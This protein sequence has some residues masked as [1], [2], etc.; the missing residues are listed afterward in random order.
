MKILIIEDEIKTAK[1]LQRIL[2]CFKGFD[3]E[4]LA[5][6]DSVEES[7]LYLNN[8]PHPDL[9]FSDI[10]LADGLCFEIFNKISVKSPVI[11]C[12][13]FDSYMMEAFD[14]N[15]V[16]YILKPVSVQSVEAALQKFRL[17]QEAFEPEKAAR[18]ISALGQQ[19]KSNYKITLLVEQRERIVPLKVNDIAF[20]YLD[21]KNVVKITTLNSQRYFMASSLDEVEGTIS[22]Q[23]FYRANRQFLINR[24]AV[25]S[26][27]RY[28]S[29]KLV[30]K[31]SAE[32]PEIIIISKAKASDFLRWLEG[33]FEA[34]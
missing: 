1:E 5:I 7:L 17:M 12:T 30:A 8:N 26:V 4:I 31:L 22:H 27:E 18:T 16:S 21:K 33:G 6:I 3:I 14:V 28:F 9:I 2:L 11:F 29:R 25:E 13:A 10:Q 19:M 24:D 23:Q 32:V 15:A 34:G 20:F